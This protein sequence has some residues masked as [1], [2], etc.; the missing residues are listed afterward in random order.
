MNKKLWE[1]SK[2]LKN[3][4]NLFKFEK[5]ISNRYR[6]NWLLR[7][8]IA[9]QLCIGP[10]NSQSDS[11]NT[12][13]PYQ[14]KGTK[15][16]VC[17]KPETVETDEGLF[18]PCGDA[19]IEGDIT[20]HYKVNQLDLE[21]HTEVN[22][23]YKFGKEH[24][25]D[26]KETVLLISGDIVPPEDFKLVYRSIRKIGIEKD[27]TGYSIWRMIPPDGYVSL[28]DVIIKGV[29]GNKP[30]SNLYAC[31]PKSCA[32]PLSATDTNVKVVWENK[33]TSKDERLQQG[34]N[35]VLDTDESAVYNNKIKIYQIKSEQG[36]N[37][38]FKTY[39]SN[40]VPELYEIKSE[41][42]NNH[43]KNVNNSSKWHVREKN[44]EDYSI[45]SHFNK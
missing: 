9:R 44:S 7:T 34:S 35:Y 13:I 19:F 20:D 45:Y 41:C 12:Y 39:L 5:L 27:V 26:P 29:S 31:V 3:N 1:A 14:L 18:K 43:V 10:C 23:D 16:I 22:M 11:N 25:G 30:D 32:I 40:E 24:Y 36:N 15:A 6:P 38:I 33:D 17:Y 42:F 4:S 37:N 8:A 21:P 28:G 2:H